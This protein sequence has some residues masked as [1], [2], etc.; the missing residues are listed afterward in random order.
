MISNSFGAEATHFA[1]ITALLEI[2]FNLVRSLGV[3]PPV[4]A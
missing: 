4:L 2:R 1:K 3:G